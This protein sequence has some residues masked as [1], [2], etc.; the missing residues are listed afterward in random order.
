MK[1]MS[2]VKI[3]QEKRFEIRVVLL[4]EKSCVRKVQSQYVW[5]VFMFVKGLC[6]VPPLSVIYSYA[7]N[8][9]KIDKSIWING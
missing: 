7:S 5:L 8:Y 3:L 4:C 1:V 6:L 2:S 9:W